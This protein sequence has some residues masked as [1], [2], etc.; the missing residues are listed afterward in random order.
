MI[1]LF[2]A[3]A[4]LTE[5]RALTLI[6]A[7]VL[8]SHRF[9]AVRDA[10]PPSPRP[11]AA[12]EEECL[13]GGE[14]AATELDFVALDRMDARLGVRASILR[15]LRALRILAWEEEEP[16][17]GLTAVRARDLSSRRLAV[18]L[19]SPYLKQKFPRGWERGRPEQGRGAEAVGLEAQVRDSD[20]GGRF[21]ICERR[22]RK[23]GRRAEG[24]REGLG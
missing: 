17:S 21:R 4:L 3:S 18:G 24:L 15:W 20:V 10:P 9:A 7:V 5:P 13:I 1:S 2:I 16:G 14:A 11:P 19:S 12:A 22:R 8:L 23:K 6:H